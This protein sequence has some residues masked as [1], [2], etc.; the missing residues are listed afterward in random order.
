[1]SYV[2]HDPFKFVT[3]SVPSALVA[4]AVYALITVAVVRPAGR[5]GYLTGT[6]RREPASGRLTDGVGAGG[7]GSAG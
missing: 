5:G 2:S 7:P 3:A 4:A 1:V 6:P